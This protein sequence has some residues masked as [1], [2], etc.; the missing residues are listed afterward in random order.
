[1][2]KFVND[3]NEKTFKTFVDTIV[4]SKDPF[5]RI[6][7]KTRGPVMQTET[8]KQTLELRDKEEEEEPLVTEVK[9]SE[10]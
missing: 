7:R 10:K 6:K 2:N 4:K 8:A 3:E 5:L 1:M 9:D